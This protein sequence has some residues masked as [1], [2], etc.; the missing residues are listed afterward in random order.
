MARRRRLDTTPE[1]K[2]LKAHAAQMK[3]V[4]LRDLFAA[5]PARGTAFTL[6]TGSWYLDYSKNLITTETLKL[7]QAL[8]P[9]ADLRAEI[10]AMFSGQKINETEKRPVLH[11][12]LRNRSNTPIYVD[13][14]DVMPAVNAV[15]TFERSTA[16]R[17][18]DDTFSSRR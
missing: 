3:G 16:R 7:L 15:F 9:L 2:A 1:W 6:E 13:R 4:S 17:R 11:V 5:D 8:C 10:D 18:R 14:K 12:A